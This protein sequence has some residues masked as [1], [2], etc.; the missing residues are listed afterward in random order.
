M[1]NNYWLAYKLRLKRRRLLFRALRKRNQLT[2]IVNRTSQIANDDILVYSTVRNEKSRLPY[3]L[4]YY[5]NMGVN[6]FLFVDNN[7]NDGTLD[8]LKQQRDVSLWTT[9]NSYKL[10]RFGVDWLAW[11]QIK[12]GHGHWC[13]VVDADEFL[14]YPFCDKRP[15]SDLTD[16][17]DAKN[18]QS[19]GTLMLDMYPK[20]QLDAHIYQPGQDPF[21][22]LN[23]FDAGNYRSQVQP[24]LQ[25]LWIQGGVRDRV[26]FADNPTR[27]PTL[28][29]TPLVKWNRRF[30]YVSSTHS[31]L[32][33]KLNNVF[34]E[35]GKKG[36]SG[37]LLHAKF[38]HM[39]VENSR[40]EKQRQEHFANSTLYDAY[41]D[42]LADS[43]DLWREESVKYTDWQQLEH[44]G[45]LKKG[46]W[47]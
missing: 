34:D 23:W 36:V 46:M 43:P 3:F 37:V 4:E 32:P 45:L 22:I 14:V 25:N 27:A 16:W 17:L 9:K 10:S 28:N 24:E 13:L 11:L 44:L 35:S 29:K 26:F 5:R 19:F 47:K 20:G 41:Y 6:H 15:L 12:Y 7:S 33:R 39:V 8:Y 38:L 18:I 40:E 31:L 30:V 42:S 1:G 2:P 21:E